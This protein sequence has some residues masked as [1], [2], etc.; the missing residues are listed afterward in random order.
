VTDVVMPQLG[1]PGLAQRLSPLYPDMRVLYISG[2]TDDAVF[3]HG[4]L[5]SRI[6]FLPKPFSPEALLR[7]VREVLDT[8]THFT[9]T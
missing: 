3:R 4:L 2:Y 5:E 6:P 9:L 7:K 8:P 1:G